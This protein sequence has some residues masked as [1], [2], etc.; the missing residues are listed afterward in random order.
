[1]NVH[2]TKILHRYGNDWSVWSLNA[3][4]GYYKEKSQYILTELALQPSKTSVL[5][6]SKMNRAIWRLGLLS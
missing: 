5:I 1:V 4:T 2:N 3:K 6:Q